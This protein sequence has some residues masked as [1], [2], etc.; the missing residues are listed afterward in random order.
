MDILLLSDVY[1]P[2]IN[3]V[4]TSIRAY[5]RNLVREVHR[6]TLVAPDYGPEARAAQQA[7]DSA[8]GNALQLLRLPAM[9]L[10]FAPEDRLFTHEDLRVAFRS[11]ER[12]VGYEGVLTCR[13]CWSP[14]L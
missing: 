3:G 14:Y 1:F 13:S 5:A 9:V 4:S 8:F 7:R 2:R 6:V 11:E 10:P 12:R